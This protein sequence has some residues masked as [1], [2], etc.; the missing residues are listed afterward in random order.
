MDD[1]LI[2]SIEG[3]ECLLLSCIYHINGARPR[4]GWLSMRRAMNLCEFAFYLIET[5]F[6]VS[7]SMMK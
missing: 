1:E 7:T 5:Y 4:S 3:I 2:G 6:G